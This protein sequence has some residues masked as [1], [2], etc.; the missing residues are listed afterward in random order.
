MISNLFNQA[1]RLFRS[2][3]A[4]SPQDYGL[5]FNKVALII[6]IF[7][8]GLSLIYMLSCIGEDMP[9]NISKPETNIFLI[10]R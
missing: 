5:N 6:S 9:E 1:N 3:E 4:N 2:C 8:Y 10:H 7:M